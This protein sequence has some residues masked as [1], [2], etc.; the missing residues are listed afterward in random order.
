MIQFVRKCYVELAA[1]FFYLFIVLI[2]RSLRLKI[3]GAENFY[4]LKAASRE[5]VFIFWHQATFIPL[6][7]YRQRQACIL[8]M[9]SV[10]GEVLARAAQRLNY[11]VILL[12]GEADSKGLRQLIKLA[13]QGHDCNLAVD[14]PLGPAYKIKPGALF[15][16]QK[17]DRPILPT[18]AAARPGWNIP[19][20]WDKYL[21]PWPFA[22]AV[23]ILG[24]PIYPQQLSLE[25]LSEKCE[26]A[27]T[28]LNHQAEAELGKS[29]L[30][31]ADRA[32]GDQ[33]GN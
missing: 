12:E 19:W 6:Y 11:Q 4:N 14:G 29:D 18:V 7:H 24:E 8:T 21:I 10:R 25:E 32:A 30:P 20:R 27:L 9:N 16:A 5:I 33:V 31:L 3:I 1:F 23:L 26:Q 28:K 17:L 15:L 13:R 2:N 22:R